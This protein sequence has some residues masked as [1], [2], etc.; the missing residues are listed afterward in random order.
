MN[1]LGKMRA[2]FS[3]KLETQID[4]KNYLG[5]DIHDVYNNVE[6]TFKVCQQLIAAKREK[7]RV[8]QEYEKNIKKF[9]GIQQIEGLSKSAMSE[10]ESYANAYMDT[11]QHKDDYVNRIKGTGEALDYLDE[12]GE[13]LPKVIENIQH[14]E[15]KQRA[16][17]NDI[18]CIEGE[19]A[20]LGYKAIRLVKTQKIVKVLMIILLMV[21]AIST[22]ILATLYKTK[23]IDIIIPSIVMIV[24]IGFFGMWIYIFRRYVVHEIKKNHLLRQRAVELLNKIKLKYVHHEQ[25]LE[26]EYKK[27][28]VKSGEMLEDRYNKYNQNIQDKHRIHKISRNILSSEE[29]IEQLLSK[30]Q[31]EVDSQFFDYI[32]QYTTKA[33]RHAHKQEVENNI[34]T[35]KNT[36]DEYDKEIHLIT[37]L[38]EDVKAQD[39]SD[40]K[41]IWK[42][43]DR[44]NL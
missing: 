32:E 16:V 35:L 43:I 30:H 31:I 2:F 4:E 37:K 23:D 33:K 1:L 22:F 25:F 39:C 28:K 27:Y 26:Y 5:V 17:K 19:K 9:S 15:E 44:L 3:N 34:K 24:I 13:D 8:V 14:V 18:H 7:E 41:A 12:Y 6:N 20:E 21:F 10:L 29:D 40:D 42:M 11:T 38:L 36:M